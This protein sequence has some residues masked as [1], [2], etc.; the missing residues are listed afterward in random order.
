MADKEWNYF[1][2][3]EGIETRFVWDANGNAE[4]LLLVSTPNTKVSS[5]TIL[6]CLALAGKTPYTERT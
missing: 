4:L 3:P 2:F 6:K 1:K 5:V